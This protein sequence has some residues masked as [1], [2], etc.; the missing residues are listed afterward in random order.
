MYNTPQH[1]T[2]EGHVLPFG[3]RQQVTMFWYA[4]HSGTTTPHSISRE[5]FDTTI[6]QLC[7]KKSSHPAEAAAACTAGS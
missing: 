1:A 5:A 4:H 3:S 7:L 6:V 2:H